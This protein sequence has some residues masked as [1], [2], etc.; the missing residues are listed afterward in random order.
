[1]SLFKRHS[2]IF[3][4]PLRVYDVGRCSRCKKL[5]T[6]LQRV[7]TAPKKQM[8]PCFTLMSFQTRKVQNDRLVRRVIMTEF[9]FFP[10]GIS[11]D[12]KPSFH[13]NFLC[14]IFHLFIRWILWC[15]N[16]AVPAYGNNMQTWP[17][18]GE[19]VLSSV[20]TGTNDVRI[21]ASQ[22]RIASILKSESKYDSHITGWKWSYYLL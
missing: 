15:P 16:Q 18:H 19:S 22:I 13:D 20:R 6:S 21:R 9:T 3:S 8:S 4:F 7:L 11:I 12:L 14:F 2:I 10:Q 1:M 17:G 5:L